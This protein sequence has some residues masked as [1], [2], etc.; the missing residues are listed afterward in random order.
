MSY[1]T[2]LNWWV[3]RREWERYEEFIM[4]EWDDTKLYAGIYAGSAMK[5]YMDVDGFAEV[6]NQVRQDTQAGNPLK[7]KKKNVSETPLSE[8]EKCKVY[9]GVHPPTKEAFA[10]YARSNGENPGVMFAYAIREYRQGGRL[11]RIEELQNRETEADAVPEVP[12][13]ESEKA[14]WIADRLRERIEESGDEQVNVGEIRAV[15]NEAGAGSRFEFYRE[16]ALDKLS[17]VHHPEINGLFI[18]SRRLWDEFDVGVD[19]PALY[20]KPPEALTREEKIEGIRAVL[21]TR[22][23]V[24]SA[25]QIHFELF[26]GNW[27]L[28]HVRNLAT[29]VAEASDAT[30][31]PTA[32][33]TKVLRVTSDEYPPEPELEPVDES[34]ETEDEP[35]P[36]P[37]DE[38]DE[39]R[40][41]LE[42]EA[43][44]EM[45]ALMNAQPARTDGGEQ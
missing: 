44:D 1:L 7:T 20:R 17:Y 24:M 42:G 12:Y 9:R 41:E 2:D 6:E 11:G 45:A 14:E 35:E 23:T 28:Q 32:G 43:A 22:G 8:Q 34:A 37:E 3:P 18:S 4:D 25:N 30:Y 33:G 39:T 19:H 13:G 5:E 40:E 10:S 27:S 16:A 38:P 31:N 15:V 26:D 21:S 36:D 29:T